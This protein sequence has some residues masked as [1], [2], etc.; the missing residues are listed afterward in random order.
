MYVQIADEKDLKRD[1]NSRAVVNTNIQ[2]LEAYKKKK[3]QTQIIEMI[4]NDINSLKQDIQ[5]I[6]QLLR[7][8]V[9]NDKI[10]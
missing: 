8:L 6:K 4:Q 7:D 3:Q 1:Q 10:S 9:I 5:C 2:S